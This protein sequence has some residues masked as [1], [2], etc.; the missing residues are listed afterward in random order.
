M[1]Y[2]LTSS[3]KATLS[4]GSHVQAAQ[5]SLDQLLGE[6]R[7]RR[8][9]L[10]VFGA[11][12]AP[13]LYV[14]SFSWKFR[15][16]VFILRSEKSAT[17]FRVAIFPGTDI[18]APRMVEWQYHGLPDWALRAVLSLAEPG[19]PG[20]P[21]GAETSHPLCTVPPSLRRDVTTRKTGLTQSDRWSWF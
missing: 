11:S 10:H 8:W 21:S 14:A 13:D 19:K 3:A 2:R 5:L 1:D 4:S 6:L 9:T 17:A 20:A 18:L 12:D 16:D 15:A 7:L